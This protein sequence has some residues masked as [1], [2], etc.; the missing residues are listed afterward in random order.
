MLP[1]LPRC[2]DVGLKIRTVEPS[3]GQASKASVKSGAG[4]GENVV[5]GKCSL[6]LLGEGATEA[7]GSEQNAAGEAVGVGGAVKTRGG[8]PRS[9]KVGAAHPHGVQ[10]V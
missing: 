10:D 3:D 6:L 1:V 5:N 7:V 2:T 8:G 4:V 9:G